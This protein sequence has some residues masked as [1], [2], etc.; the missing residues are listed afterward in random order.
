MAAIQLVAFI[1]SCIYAFQFP[2]VAETQRIS[3]AQLKLLKLES[4]LIAPSLP[5]LISL[6]KCI[7][8]RLKTNITK[9]VIINTQKKLF[10]EQYKETSSSDSS[11]IDLKIRRILVP[12][13]TRKA[14]ML[15]GMNYSNKPIIDTATKKKSKL[16]YGLLKQHVNPQPISLI[17][18]SIINRTTKTSLKP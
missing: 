12:L 8:S 18:A 14:V 16:F 9:N 15:I 6:N 3:I 1:V 13:R 5:Y 10:K 7:P 17:T 2:P 11:C 4:L